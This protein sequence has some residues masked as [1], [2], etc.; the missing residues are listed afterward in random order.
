MRPKQEQ[1]KGLFFPLP[2]QG[3]ICPGNERDIA[4]HGRRAAALI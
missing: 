3:N 4:E 1:A 2:S